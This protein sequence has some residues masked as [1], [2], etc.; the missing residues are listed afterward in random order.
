MAK[1]DSDGKTELY[2][3][4]T[5]S[6][7]R[8]RVNVGCMYINF[9]TLVDEKVHASATDHIA[10][11]HN[12]QSAVRRHLVVKGLVRWRF[13]HLRLMVLPNQERC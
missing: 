1:I 8:E 3:G 9:T 2:D 6:K 13:G 4:R 5:G 10:L 7:I 12:N 11:L